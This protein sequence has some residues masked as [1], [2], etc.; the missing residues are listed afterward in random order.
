MHR[1][2]I[3]RALKLCQ[4]LPVLKERMHRVGLHKTAQKMEAAVLEIGYGGRK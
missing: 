4:E 1:I 3:A 2:D